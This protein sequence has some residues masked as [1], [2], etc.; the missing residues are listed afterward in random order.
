MTRRA[1]RA[2]PNGVKN[3]V[4]SSREGTMAIARRSLSARTSSHPYSLSSTP[5]E[6]PPPK[7]KAAEALLSRLAV[8]VGDAGAG[9]EGAVSWRVQ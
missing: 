4:L 8:G 2:T 5:W 9:G 3:C 6:R 7:P 1:A